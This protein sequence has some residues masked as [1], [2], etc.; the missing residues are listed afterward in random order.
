MYCEKFLVKKA[1]YE[2]DL[3]TRPV[4]GTVMVT[5][6]PVASVFAPRTIRIF[7]PVIVVI[8]PCGK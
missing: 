7:I 4:E 2:M 6:T 5:V 3:V 8:V 1:K